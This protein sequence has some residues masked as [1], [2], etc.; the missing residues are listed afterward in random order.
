MAFLILPFYVFTFCWYRTEQKLQF[1]IA[2]IVVKNRFHIRDFLSVDDAPAGDECDSREFLD[3][4][5]LK[6]NVA[7]VKVEN[8]IVCVVNFTGK[9]ADQTSLFPSWFCC[10]W[11]FCCCFLCCHDAVI[12]NEQRYNNFET[13]HTWTKMLKSC[14]KSNTGIITCDSRKIL[15]LIKQ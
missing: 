13:Y 5:K 12:L 1:D 11:L 7:S 2:H 15:D 4:I 14:Q 9:Y 6:G 10:C 3:L 8:R